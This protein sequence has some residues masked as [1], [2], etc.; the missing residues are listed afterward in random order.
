M[1]LADKDTGAEEQE[2]REEALALALLIC[3]TA[4][5][6]LHATD[7]ERAR[8]PRNGFDEAFVTTVGKYVQEVCKRHNVPQE[9]SLALLAAGV[10]YAENARRKM[11][12]ALPQAPDQNDPNVN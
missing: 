7:E 11:R 1:N 2:Q 3:F 8:R 12:E 5:A 9:T 10:Q 6:F 4:G